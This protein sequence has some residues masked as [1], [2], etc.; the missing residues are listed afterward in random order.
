VGDEHVPR[1][2]STWSPKTFALVGRLPSTL[3][4]RSIVLA[5]RRRLKHQ[6]VAS[7]EP[8]R[9]AAELLAVRRKLVG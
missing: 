6:V 3:K 8:Q 4:D 2:F 1:P 5:M 7:W 9:M